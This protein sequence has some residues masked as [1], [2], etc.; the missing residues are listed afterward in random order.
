M[1]EAKR[2]RGSDPDY[3]KPRFDAFEV[4]P[5]HSQHGEFSIGDRLL[6][7][8]DGCILCGRTSGVHRHPDGSWCYGAAGGGYT[9][10]YARLVELPP[11]MGGAVGHVCADARNQQQ[12]SVRLP[13]EARAATERGNARPA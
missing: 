8:L 13:R 12:S 7:V 10:L 6:T 3:G 9:A 5:T 2:R 1:G 11:E 4:D